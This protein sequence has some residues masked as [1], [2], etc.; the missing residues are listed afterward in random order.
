MHRQL[1]LQR[2]HMEQQLQFFGKT[3]LANNN[4]NNSNNNN[5][6][7]TKEKVSPLETDPEEKP[8]GPGL[9]GQRDTPAPP[10]AVKQTEADLSHAK[11]KLDLWTKCSGLHTVDKWV[12]NYRKH[13][14]G[15]GALLMIHGVPEVTARLRQKVQNYATFSAL[16]LS[17]AIKAMSGKLPVCMPDPETWECEVRKR[18]YAYSFALAIAA[19]LLCIL[20]AMAFHNALNEAARDSDVFRMF[21]AVRFII[22]CIVASCCCCCCC[23]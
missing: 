18:V 19:L 14:A 3:L 2:Q 17:G 12:T 11:S 20:L 16:F 6:Q 1:E 4:S 10:A 21:A 8:L 7:N 23:C 13:P 5:N 9:V 15:W 22:F